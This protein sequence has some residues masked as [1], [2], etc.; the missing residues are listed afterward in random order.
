M[1]EKLVIWGAGSQA[2][3]VADI[4]RLREQ[5]EI[6]GFLDSVSPERAHTKFCGASI[7]GGEEQLDALRRQGVLNLICAVGTARARLQLTVLARAKGFQLVTAIH[8]TA[9]IAS[10]VS[11]G[12]GT[13][14]MAGAIV[15]PAARV[16]ENAIINVC[17]SVDHECTIEDAVLIGPG[18]HLG[19]GVTVEHAATVEIGATIAG[20][21]RIGAESVVGAGSVVLADIP[22]R[23][24]A[25]GIPAKVIRSIP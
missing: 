13:V 6:V 10:G 8:P 19:G 25:Y 1:R 16:G 15:N 11:I 24:L 3:I 18:A 23:V 17:A 9:V 21:L 5:Y 12:A 4:I 22:S 2:L 20:G 7:L 14:I